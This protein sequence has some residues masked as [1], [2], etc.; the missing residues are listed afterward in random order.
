MIKRIYMSII[1]FIISITSVFSQEKLEKIYM[2]E[3]GR[4]EET[5]NVLDQCA[6]TVWKGWKGYAEV[7]FIFNY[8][9][10]VRL[11]V[12]YPVKPDGFEEVTGVTVRDKKVYID[13]RNEIPLKLEPPLG[14]GGGPRSFG[15]K[16]IQT[17]HI[18]IRARFSIN[19]Y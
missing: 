8:P 5:W 19:V 17:V 18:S 9:N 6:E 3:L 2:I 11:L 7:P 14:G 16:R 15:P 10:G 1:L 4:L 12:G 13:R